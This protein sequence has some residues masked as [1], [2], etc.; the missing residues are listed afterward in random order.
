MQ[1]QAAEYSGYAGPTRE[2]RMLRYCVAA[3]ARRARVTSIP[4]RKPFQSAAK[5]DLR[6]SVAGINRLP[7]NLDVDDRNQSVTIYVTRCLP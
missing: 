5:I 7:H 4:D 2:T 1:A 6:H 3:S